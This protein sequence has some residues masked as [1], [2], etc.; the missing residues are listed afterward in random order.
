MKPTD[1]QRT[2]ARVMSQ[3]FKYL[4]NSSDLNNPYIYT[5]I[6]EELQTLEEILS[7]KEIANIRQ[8]IYELFITIKE[9]K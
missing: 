8:N 2:I 9:S 1:D 4:D 6:D 3:I 7:L 5:Y